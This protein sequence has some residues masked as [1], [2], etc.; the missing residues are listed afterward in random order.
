LASVPDWKWTA[1]PVAFVS[2]AYIDAVDGDL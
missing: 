1:S 2:L